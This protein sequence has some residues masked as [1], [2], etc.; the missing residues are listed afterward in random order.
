[1]LQDALHRI[2]VGCEALVQHRLEVAVVVRELEDV[3]LFRLEVTEGR[4]HR[5][6]KDEARVEV[7]QLVP[8]FVEL[9]ELTEALH[10]DFLHTQIDLA[11]ELPLVRRIEVEEAL[12]PGEHTEDALHGG[13]VVEIV[14]RR[15]VN[16]ALAHEDLADVIALRANDEDTTLLR[17]CEEL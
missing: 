15:V 12:L 16:D 8:N 7:G 11:R 17:S 5:L 6:R 13:H 2:E 14:D 4:N 3:E 9:V 10:Q 1:Q